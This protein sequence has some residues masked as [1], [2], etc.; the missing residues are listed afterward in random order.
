[1]YLSAFESVSVSLCFIMSPA[2]EKKTCSTLKFV[3]ALCS[4]CF[5]NISVKRVI[6]QGFTSQ[7]SEKQPPPH[8]KE[9]KGSPWKHG[10]L[11]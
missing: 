4:K 11:F 3:L 9:R 1:M 2:I 10:L 7:S 5:N 8:S 6:L